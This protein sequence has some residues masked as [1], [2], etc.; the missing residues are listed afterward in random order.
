VGGRERFAESTVSLVRHDREDPESNEAAVAHLRIT[1]KDPDA[2]K[3]GRAFSN[4]AIE[5]ALA[6]YPGFHTT[7]PP[8]DESAFA[9]YWPAVLPAELVE[10]VVHVDGREIPVP[11]V[12][13]APPGV[14]PV[15]P[16]ARPLPPAPRGPTVRA[17]LG[18]VAGARSGDKGGNANVGVWAR[19]PEGYAW[20]LETL[21]SERLRGLLP[22][23]RGLA[24]AR[25][26]LPNL[27]AI[28]FVIEGLLGEG[29][30]AATRSDPQAK[31]LGEYLRARHLDIPEALLA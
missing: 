23:A 29:V 12:T 14:P 4:R 5:M 30:A 15:V 9:V 16:P 10:Q 6:H 2:G 21:T 19:T 17:P 26:P 3:V 25:H 8:G 22:E 27:L 20:L 28:N 7:A 11:P 18:R 24:V 13:P 1:V 31:G